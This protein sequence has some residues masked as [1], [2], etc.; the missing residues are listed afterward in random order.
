M[1][2]SSIAEWSGFKSFPHAGLLMNIYI[3]QAVIRKN[4]WSKP[5]DPIG[6]N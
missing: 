2:T 3:I 5:M 6:G 4:T 1:T